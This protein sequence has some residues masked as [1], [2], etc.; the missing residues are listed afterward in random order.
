MMTHAKAGCRLSEQT[1]RREDHDSSSVDAAIR[2][3]DFQVS[4][5]NREKRIMKVTFFANI[6]QFEPGKVS[7]SNAA[8]IVLSDRE[9]VAGQI[10]STTSEHIYKPAMTDG[11][12]RRNAPS[13]QSRVATAVQRKRSQVSHKINWMELPLRLRR[14]L[15]D[16]W[17]SLPA[18]RNLQLVN[19]G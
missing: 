11:T 5:Q 1:E 4:S 19:K 6:A 9:S 16:S 8:F 17:T 7:C 2:A 13:F 3:R 10:I 14:K 12:H 15:I 18:G